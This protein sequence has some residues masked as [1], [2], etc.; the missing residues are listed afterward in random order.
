MQIYIQDHGR[1]CFLHPFICISKYWKGILQKIDRS[2]IFSWFFFFIEF[3]LEFE[4][5]I[6]VLHFVQKFRY[7]SLSIQEKKLYW[8]IP[9]VYMTSYKTTFIPYN[10]TLGKIFPFLMLFISFE[11]MNYFTMTWIHTHNHTYKN[12]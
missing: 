11:E 7:D 5:T 3:Y 10:S 1:T 2:I 6:F 4:K 9:L 12:E 8:R